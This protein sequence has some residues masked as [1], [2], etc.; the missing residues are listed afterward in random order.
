MDCCVHSA[1]VHD[2]CLIAQDSTKHLQESYSHLLPLPTSPWLKAE[3]CALSALQ[4][5]LVPAGDSSLVF[6]DLRTVCRGVFNARDRRS[7]RLVMTRCWFFY[8]A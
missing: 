8:D 3:S 5:L 7:L 2:G 1:S 6:V 4:K